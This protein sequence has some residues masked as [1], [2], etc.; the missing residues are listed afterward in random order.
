MGLKKTVEIA[1]DFA[2]TGGAIGTQLQAAALPGNCLVTNVHVVT[3]T[4][5]T[6]GGAATVAIVAGA[7]TILGATAIAALPGAGA[8]W[9]QLQE[10]AIVAGLGGLPLV[11]P[12]YQN[13]VYLAT[14]GQLGF[15][16]GAFALTAGILFIE[17]EYIEL[18]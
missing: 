8:A 4:P 12:P 5:V 10:N 17:I 1:Y 15:V 2:F 3:N 18:N 13:D 11:T 6:S 14:P 7:T 9:D 16:I